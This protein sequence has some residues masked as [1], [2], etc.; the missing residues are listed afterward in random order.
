MERIFDLFVFVLLVVF[1]QMYRMMNEREKK[2]FK[3][4]KQPSMYATHTHR[5]LPGDECTE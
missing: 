2:V 4:N 1:A 3:A 5:S